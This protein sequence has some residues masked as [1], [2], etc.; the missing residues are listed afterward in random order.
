MIDLM[1]FYQE[2]STK[3]LWN[4][5]IFLYFNHDFSGN[6]FTTFMVESFLISRPLNKKNTKIFVVELVFMVE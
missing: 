1:M 5:F 6:Y 2:I 3:F 4:N